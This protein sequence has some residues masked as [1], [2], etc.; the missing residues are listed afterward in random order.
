M[1]PSIKDMFYNLDQTAQD[2]WKQYVEKG[3]IIADNETRDKRIEICSKCEFYKPTLG[4]YRCQKCGC[5]MKLK[6]RIAA[7]KC[8]E[9]FW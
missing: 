2:V 1:S 7:A 3:V 8:E 9:G 6:V 5:G 4:I